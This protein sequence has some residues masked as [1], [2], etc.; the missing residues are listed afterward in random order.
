M[1]L[2]VAIQALTMALV[3]LMLIVLFVYFAAAHKQ[4]VTTWV[5]RISIVSSLSSL[6][7]SKH[8]EA[9]VDEDSY[10]RYSRVDYDLEPSSGE[11]WISM[12]PI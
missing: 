12:K 3:A 2:I 11:T 4:R 6:R 9:E 5:K 10:K 8:D 1:I 7:L